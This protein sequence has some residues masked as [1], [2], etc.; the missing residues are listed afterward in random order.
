MT[1]LISQDKDEGQV[2]SMKRQGVSVE[3]SYQLCRKIAK[4]SGSN[5]YQGM[6]FTLDR[7]KRQALFS[8]YAWMRAI[9]DIADGDL[10]LEEK[11]KQLHDFF[12]QTE[13]LYTE[14]AHLNEATFWLALQHT[15][16]QYPIPLTYFREMFLG[17][18][19][20]IQQNTYATF[21][22]LYQYC[23][24]VASIVGLIC[25]SIWGYEGGNAVLQ[26]A[27]Y[28]G[29][30]LQ[31]T[32]IVR[33]VYADAQEGK[34]FIPAEWIEKQEELEQALNK[35][36]EQAEY[37]YQASRNLDKMVS[38]RGSLSLQLM[39]ASYVVLLSKIKKM[40]QEVLKGNTIKL[41]RTEKLTVCITGIVKWCF[42]A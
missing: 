4:E 26:L 12:H 23:Y 38:R 34:L 19:Q 7:H 11:T 29:V 33:D 6:W 20:S 5:F 25:V 14:P 24:R 41:S 9:D 22:E 35:T 28:R 42:A 40:P 21:P 30:A 3:R 2:M 8:I 32:N 36:I 13:K 15:I 16:R 1:G 10:E 31:L 27:E 37:Y 18:L 17:Q 39:T